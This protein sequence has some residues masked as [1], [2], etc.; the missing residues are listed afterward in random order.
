M[1]VECEDL[2]RPNVVQKVEQG[3]FYRDDKDGDGEIPAVSEKLA[4]NV[5]A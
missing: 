3:P 5:Q 4:E 2:R 1:R